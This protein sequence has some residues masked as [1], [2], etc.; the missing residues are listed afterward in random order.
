MSPSLSRVAD[1]ICAWC[2]C[3]SLCWAQSHESRYQISDTQ[4]RS[5]TH[6]RPVSILNP[7]FCTAVVSRPQTIK[8][9]STSPVSRAKYSQPESRLA[10]ISCLILSALA[11]IV[12]VRRSF[13]NSNPWLVMPR[14]NGGNPPLAQR[15]SLDEIHVTPLP[16]PPA[17]TMPSWGPC[18]TP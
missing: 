7:T 3:V 8:A 6:T 4:G 15:D 17:G 12:C 14:A 9:H 16:P 1:M 10:L 13:F 2:A 18:T 5:H 11:P